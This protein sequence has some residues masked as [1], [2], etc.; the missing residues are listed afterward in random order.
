MTRFAKWQYRIMASHAL[1]TPYPQLKTCLSFFSSSVGNYSF[2]SLQR[3]YSSQN[4]RFN[5]G[6]NKG[7]SCNL[8]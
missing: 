7:F 5:S 6:A 4:G 8:G 2:R 1:K 3:R